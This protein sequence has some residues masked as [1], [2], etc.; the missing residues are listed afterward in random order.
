MSEIEQLLGFDIPGATMTMENGILVITKPDLPVNQYIQVVETPIQEK[1]RICHAPATD[2]DREPPFVG[3][4][5]N[6][7]TPTC[8]HGSYFAHDKC[9]A[10]LND[11]FPL[12]DGKVTPEREKAFEPL[13]CL[14]CGCECCYT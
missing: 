12:V 3:N 2:E 10:K 6:W 4:R 13:K 1:C 5:L 14:V 8:G 9:C 11:D 7:H